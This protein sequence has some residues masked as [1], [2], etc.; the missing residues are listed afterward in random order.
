MRQ[1]VGLFVR[2]YRAEYARLAPGRLETLE[3]WIA[4]LAACR[5][6]A[7][8][9]HEHK[10]LLAIIEVSFELATTMKCRCEKRS[11]GLYLPL[12]RSSPFIVEEIASLA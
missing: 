6:Q 2:T 8:N 12:Q 9:P 10:H 5:F 4:V 7:D 3:T 11:G 1:Y